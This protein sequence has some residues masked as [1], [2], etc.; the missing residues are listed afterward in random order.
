MIFN[1]N[2]SSSTTSATNNN[3]N[4]RMNFTLKRQIVFYISIC[5]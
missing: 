5:W 3:R 4:R 1:P 2:L